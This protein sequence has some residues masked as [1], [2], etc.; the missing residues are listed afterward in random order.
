ME[1]NMQ[2]NL[3]ERLAELTDHLGTVLEKLDLKLEVLRA[4]K[5]SVVEFVPCAEDGWSSPVRIVFEDTPGQEPSWED[6]HLMVKAWGCRKLGDTGFVS[7]KC[8]HEARHEIR[9]ENEKMFEWLGFVL[10]YNQLVPPWEGVPNSIVNPN[11][12]D[13]HD[14]VAHWAPDHQIEQDYSGHQRSPLEVFKFKD[15]RGREIEIGMRYI[16]TQEAT[17]HIDGRFV[18]EFS[19]HNHTRFIEIVRGLSKKYNGPYKYGR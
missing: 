3:E 9:G 8:F 6:A 10:D 14:F 1:A 2:S 17:V 15:A 4:V 5:S 19:Q 12:G 11:F 18:E 7:W 16:E 13:L